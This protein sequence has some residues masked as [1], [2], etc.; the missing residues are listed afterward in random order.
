MI[1]FTVCDVP[2]SSMVRSSLW[3]RTS[4]SS[5]RCNV[6][7]GL[8]DEIYH[9]HAHEDH[10]RKQDDVE[11]SVRRNE[12]EG[13]Q[14]VH[15]RGDGEHVHEIYSERI[16]SD[17]RQHDRDKA[18]MRAEETEVLYSNALMS[19]A[20]GNSTRDQRK[21]EPRDARMA[22][23]RSVG[24]MAGQI[25]SLDTH[26]VIFDLFPQTYMPATKNRRKGTNM[27]IITSTMTC[28][29]G[30][31]V[32]MIVSRSPSSPAYHISRERGRRP[33]AAKNDLLV[34]FSCTMRSRTGTGCK[35][36]G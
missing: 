34:L 3:K 32:P 1:I 30:A 29:Q 35:V 18:T 12:P 15:D 36:R 4:S 25:L 13:V 14:T 7:K 9:D 2:S 33:V 31:E 27:R 11:Q 28:P 16:H 5:R 23:S 22:A 17:G 20:N 6:H 10:R 24:M 21:P 19:I 8:V 26:P